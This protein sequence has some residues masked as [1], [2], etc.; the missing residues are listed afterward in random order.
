MS[1]QIPKLLRQSRSSFVCGVGI[2]TVL[3]FVPSRATSK[4]NRNTSRTEKAPCPLIETRVSGPLRHIH[5]RVY[6]AIPPMARFPSQISPDT[7][8]DQQDAK[9]YLDMCA[10][11]HS[12]SQVRQ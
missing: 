7:H 3:S 6:Y 9:M 5:A 8:Q 10:L 4:D 12:P 1:E 2:F 11:I